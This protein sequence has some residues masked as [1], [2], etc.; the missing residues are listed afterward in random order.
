[1]KTII[2]YFTGTG[3]SLAAARK[4]SAVLGDCELVPIATLQDTPGDIVPAADRVGI[5]CPIYDFGLPSIV[6]EFAGRLDLSKA[7]Y[8]FCVLTMGGMGV[9]ALHQANAIVM[10]KNGRP[11]TAAWAVQVVGN[12]VP[13][14]A[15]PEGSKREKLL[16]GSGHRIREIAGLIDKGIAVTPGFAPFSSLLKHLMYDGMMKKIHDA[17][18]DFIADE[19]C[20]R[21]GTCANVCPVK[22]I[23]IV[24]GKPSWQHHCELCMAC[25]NLCPA[26]AIQWGPKT[27]GRG[28]YHHPDLK[29][30]DMKTQAG[31]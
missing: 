7:G 21:C 11:F 4:I 8:T 13:L 25:L 9:S 14:Y 17:D 28:R 16:D 23:G 10:K 26:Q 20:T 19:R 31:R 3:N 24:D 2:Y 22:N 27:K 29:I 12:F 5:V 6:S 15:P 30:A 1:M 18:N